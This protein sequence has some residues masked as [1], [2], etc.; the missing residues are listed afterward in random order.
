[1]RIAEQRW[2]NTL[3]QLEKTLRVSMPH[4]SAVI[5]LSVLGLFTLTSVGCSSQSSSLNDA[6][7][8]D[9]LLT[10]ADT[11]YHAKRY[12]AAKKIYLEVIDGQQFL[13]IT[14][15]RLGNIFYSEKNYIQAQ[16]Y[17]LESLKQKPQAIKAHYNIANTYLRLAEFHLLFFKDN[18]NSKQ[19][20]QNTQLL[21]NS[22]K[23]FTQKKPKSN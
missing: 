12:S 6:Q 21:L 1:M 11:L 16:R 23:D 14:Y 3:L 15:Y 10:Q 7:S 13:P 20:S 22:L 9:L 17:Y 2:S 8:R 4:F 18:T 19:L 5:L